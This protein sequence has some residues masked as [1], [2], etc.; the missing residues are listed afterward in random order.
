MNKEFI[1]EGKDLEMRFVD[2][3]DSLQCFKV[4]EAGSKLNGTLI[5]LIQKLIDIE[6]ID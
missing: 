5:L 2:F 3:R 1:I 6:T 4:A